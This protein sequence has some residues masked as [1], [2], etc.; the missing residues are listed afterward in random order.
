MTYKRATCIELST[1]SRKSEIRKSV[2]INKTK[3]NGAKQIY[4]IP[5]CLMIMYD[6]ITKHWDFYIR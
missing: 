4:G 6:V 1:R 3:A 5:F 2:L